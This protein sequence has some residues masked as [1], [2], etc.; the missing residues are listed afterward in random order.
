MPGYTGE[1]LKLHFKKRDDGTYE[2]QVRESWSG[3]TARGSFA[4]PYTASQLNKLHKKL[5]ALESNEQELRV[6]GRRLFQALC[7]SET[8]GT[9]RNG[10]SEQSVQAMLRHVIQRTLQRRGTVALTFS[11]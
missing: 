3:H 10:T 7:G 2:L 11:F 5:N 4:P 9:M 6:V 8:P 1:T